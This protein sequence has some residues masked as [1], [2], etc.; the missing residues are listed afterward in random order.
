[1]GSSKS[2]TKFETWV[3]EPALSMIRVALPAGPPVRDQVTGVDLVAFQGMQL[4]PGD[5]TPYA[6]TWTDPRGNCWIVDLAS[7][8]DQH[9]HNVFLLDLETKG[10][11]VTRDMTLKNLADNLTSLLR[12]GSNP[13]FKGFGHNGRL[14]FL[15]STG[16][17]GLLQKEWLVALHEHTQSSTW[18]DQN[19]A[20]LTQI[21]G[22]LLFAVPHLGPSMAGNAYHIPCSSAWLEVL[23]TRTD[24]QDALQKLA[25]SFENVREAYGIPVLCILEGRKTSLKGLPVTKIVSDDSARLRFTDPAQTAVDA[26]HRGTSKMCRTDFILRQALAFVQANVSQKRASAASAAAVHGKASTS[27]LVRN[28]NTPFEVSGHLHVR[29]TDDVSQIQQ[30]I[31]QAGQELNC[32]IHS[33]GSVGASVVVT[34]LSSPQKSWQPAALAA[35]LQAHLPHHLHWSLSMQDKHSTSSYTYDAAKL[36]GPF[37][38]PRTDLTNAH[39]VVTDAGEKHAFVVVEETWPQHNSLFMHVEGQYTQLKNVPESDLKSAN[40]QWLAQ[41][42]HVYALPADVDLLGEPILLEAT[43]N[44]H[45]WSAPLFVPLLS[46]GA[47]DDMEEHKAAMKEED[48]NDCVSQLTEFLGIS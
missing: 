33:V 13:N 29:Q 2:K 39:L 14:T 34:M 19:K 15:L 4:Y 1:M 20:F 37:D 17:G 11:S 9:N 8:L 26:D 43:D 6:D 25:D 45:S 32:S 7:E 31:R 10:I 16:L 42:Q 36:D 40:S 24:T 28:N 3:P 38:E 23:R 21:P 5:K 27:A 44:Q 48:W 22:I 47:E 30:S 18:A 46:P 41:G 35:A 12:G